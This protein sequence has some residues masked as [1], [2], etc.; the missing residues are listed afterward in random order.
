MTLH[1]EL[2]RLKCHGY[3]PLAGVL[4]AHEMFNKQSKTIVINVGEPIPYQQIDALATARMPY[5]LSD[6][7]VNVI[8]ETITGLDFA[9]DFRAMREQ[10]TYMNVNVPTLYKQ[11]SDLCDE[12]G[13]RYIDFN[14][15]ASF[16]HC[17]DGLVLVDL[18]YLKSAKWKRYLG[19]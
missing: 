15:D 13:V 2:C 1:S 3:K 9:D 16:G 10:L 7:E 6:D 5:R 17:I 4:L 11:Y 8:N 14:I 18:T 19:S 12:G